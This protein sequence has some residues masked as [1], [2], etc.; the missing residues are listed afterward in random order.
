[1]NYHEIYKD[2]ML[3]GEG[4]RVVL[5]VAGCNH[6]CPKCQNPFT[7]DPNGGLPFDDSAKQEI[8]DQL[9]K[10]YISGITLSGGDPLYP[11][12]RPEIESLMKEIKE[13]Y[14]TKNIWMYTGYTYE[15]IKDLPL[16]KYVDVL[17]D[18]P[19]IDE[20]CY[21]SHPLQK[22]ILWVGSNN[23]RVIHLNK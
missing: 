20:L 4:L 5:W 1:M 2:N 14:P 12:N 6:N 18:G 9:D 3:N 7:H 22:Q 15:Q 19:F 11:S 13:K 21:V 23:Q 17:C 10:D 8:F 16:M